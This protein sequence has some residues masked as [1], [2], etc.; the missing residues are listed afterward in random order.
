MSRF[1]SHM[2]IILWQ[3]WITNQCSLQKCKLGQSVVWLLANASYPV[4]RRISP[5]RVLIQYKDAILPVQETRCGNK[6]IVRLSYLHN[7]IWYTG[8]TPSLYWISP[9]WQGVVPKLLWQYCCVSYVQILTLLRSVQFWTNVPASHDNFREGPSES[10][11]DRPR[12]QHGWQETTQAL[13]TVSR[14]YSH[15][16]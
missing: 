10:W 8:K 15:D 7:A 4:C 1:H 6:T 11:H 12:T 13:E 2:Y 9:R 14:S 3:R 5:T 16:F